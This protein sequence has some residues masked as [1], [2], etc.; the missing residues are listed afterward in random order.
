MAINLSVCHSCPSP[1]H[2]NSLPCSFCKTTGQSGNKASALFH[3]A[4]LGL[5]P[6]LLPPVWLLQALKFEAIIIKQTLAS[7]L[8][9]GHTRNSTSTE[10]PATEKKKYCDPYGCTHGKRLN[11]KYGQCS[12]RLNLV[13]YKQEAFFPSEPY[14]QCYHIL[15][16]FPSL[17]DSP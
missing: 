5:P 12:P 1:I 2:L 11:K 3:Q 14:R 6:S 17:R 13:K 7:T 8:R 16:P 9:S 10:E 15:S 4:Q